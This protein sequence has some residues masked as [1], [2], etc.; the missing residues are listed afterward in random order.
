MPVSR[1]QP[2][3]PAPAR[4]LGVWSSVLMS[5]L[6]AGLWVPVSQYRFI[7][8][9]TTAP[10]A[11]SYVLRVDLGASKLAKKSDGTHK[12]PVTQHESGVSS[13]AEAP[14]VVSFS[15]VSKSPAPD[16]QGHV[17]WVEKLN[18]SVLDARGPPPDFSG[19]P[20]QLHSIQN[21]SLPVTRGPPA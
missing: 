13:H 2:A 10:Q 5:V 17:D 16:N 19:T 12:N 9:V 14:S 21:Q 18:V 11:T 1:T 4:S 15:I 6:L 20:Q 8:E 3:S 7:W